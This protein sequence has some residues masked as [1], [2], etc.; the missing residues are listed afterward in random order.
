MAEAPIGSAPNQATAGCLATSLLWVQGL[1]FLLTGVWPLVSI[2]SFQWVTGP[3]TDHL[4][5][6]READHWLVMTVGVLV[7]AIAITLLTAAIRRRLPA[8]V[9]V[10]TIGAS[11]ALTGIDVV[12]VSRGVIAPI[13]LVDAAIEVVLIIG[14]LTVIAAGA[15]GRVRPAGL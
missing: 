11:L 15:S 5:T 9:I 14:W 13:Y 3:K 1:Y 4:H 8:E 2:E 6:G 7:T 10:L 12:Y